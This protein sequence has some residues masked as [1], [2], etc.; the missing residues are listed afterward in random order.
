MTV[1]RNPS[2][3]RN[4]NPD[5]LACLVLTVVCSPV[6]GANDDECGPYP[7]I[8]AFS[9]VDFINGQNRRNH[10]K[11]NQIYGGH[12]FTLPG[13]IMITCLYHFI[14]LTYGLFM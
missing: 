7:G 4:D 14:T 8:E 11:L 12:K 13:S 9:W 3:E 5:L 2:H 6:G 1:S 10:C